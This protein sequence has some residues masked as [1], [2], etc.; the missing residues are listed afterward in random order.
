L[1]VPKQTCVNQYGD[2]PEDIALGS[3]S[4]EVRDG[5]RRVHGEAVDE[6]G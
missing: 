3:F 5:L 4:R 1:N 6:D 2:A